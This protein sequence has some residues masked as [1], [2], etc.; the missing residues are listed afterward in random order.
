V[1]E[2]PA[3][4]G[5]RAYAMRMEGRIVRIIV[6]EDSLFYRNVLQRS[7]GEWGYDVIV[8]GDG[9]EAWN[10]LQNRSEDI[11]LAVI[12][13]IMPAP[14]GLELCRRIRQARLPYYV[15]VILM[16]ART[17]KADVIAALN[18]GADDYMAKPF[19]IGELRSR[20]GVG[21][22]LLKYDSALAEKNA[23]LERFS[24]EMET[25]AQKRSDQLIHADRMATVG[26]MSAR[27]AHEINNPAT[28]IAGN[29]QTL[30][31]FWEEIEP[32]VQREVAATSPNTGK[33]NLIRDQMPEVL[34]G[35][36][37]GVERIAIIVNGLKS[38]CRRDPGIH[39]VC[40]VNDCV[41]NALSLC[42]GAL[43]RHAT[44]ETLLAETLRPVLA[45]PRQIE[46]VL[47]NLFTNA[48]DAMEQ[49]A[50]D[51]RLTVTTRSP[52]NI[53]TITV[54]DTGTGIADDN[55]DDVWQPF[56]TTKSSGKGTGLGL[57]ISRDIIEAHGGTINAGNV[58]GGGARFTITLPLATPGDK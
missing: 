12:D 21:M 18:A 5:L 33:L 30:R 47:V 49:A 26:L 13:W 31:K 3:P 45:D 38:F 4:A 48:A 23:A 1:Q 50:G 51:C 16:T 10:I 43:K 41:M 36:A 28:F 9:N 34:A 32:A 53:V 15:Y 54:Q 57:S 20:V 44:V 17:A 29:V 25:L 6:A 27:I 40:S 46:Q 52:D 56:F 24:S 58:S 35:I 19:E 42:H 7:L 22:R 37:N 11:R 39:Q 2:T 55:L 14:D 8:T